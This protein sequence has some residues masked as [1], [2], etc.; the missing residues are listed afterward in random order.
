MVDEDEVDG[1][2]DENRGGGEFEMLEIVEVGEG[3]EGEGGD[4]YGEADGDGVFEDV[5]SELVF[6]AVG[7]FLEGEDEAGEADTGEVKE[8]HFDGREGIA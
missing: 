8:S 4:R 2:G 6:D 3:G 7:V 5:F 1:E